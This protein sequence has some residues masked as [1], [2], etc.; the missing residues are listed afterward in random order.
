M[1]RARILILYGRR[2][3]GKTELI[4]HVYSRR[5]LLKIEGLEGQSDYA[6]MCEVMRQLAEHTQQPLLKKITVTTWQ[7]VLQYIAEVVSTGEWTVYFEEVQWLA[8]YKSDF[9]SALKYVWDNFFR[10]NAELLLILCGSSPSFIVNEIVHSK[11]LYNRSSYEMR[12][13]KFNLI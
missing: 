2:R 1:R 8:N 11:A 13:T 9:I 10:H 6:Q 5:N 12:L 7:E 3:V 4:E